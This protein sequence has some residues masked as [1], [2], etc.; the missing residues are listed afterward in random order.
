[1][2]MTLEMAYNKYGNILF[3]TKGEKSER[4]RDELSTLTWE[5]AV[6]EVIETFNYDYFIDVGAGFGY[7]SMMASPYCEQV[8]AYEPHPIRCGVMRWNLKHLDNV[9]IHEVAIG[10]Q[11]YISP[12]DPTEMASSKGDVFTEKLDIETIPS[13]YSYGNFLG[14]VRDG[15]KVLAKI[16]TEGYEKVILEKAFDP[17]TPLSVLHNT[18]FIIEVHPKWKHLDVRG[19]DIVPFFDYGNWVGKEIGTRNHWLFYWEEK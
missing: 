13:I 3:H 18:T 11:P 6:T 2:R 14:R 16:D 12:D 9:N 15:A 5:P 7:Y 1:M 17:Y 10:D 4:I 19:E 8:Y